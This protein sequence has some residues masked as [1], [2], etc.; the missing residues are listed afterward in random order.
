MA[1]NDYISSS[2]ITDNVL[3][4]LVTTAYVTEGNDAIEQLTYDK[5]L[6]ITDIDY[7]PLN[8]NVKRYG[9]AWTCWRICV[10]YM[11]TNN[12][13]LPVEI[14][15][16]AVKANQYRGEIDTLSYKIVPYMI[17]GDEIGDK[18]DRA[19]IRTRYRG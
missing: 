18:S 4:A 9:V 11:G 6:D 1:T 2:D 14:E 19:S 10:D 12:T 7:D 8:Y 13:D 16:Y 15:K 5:G 17:T 3:S